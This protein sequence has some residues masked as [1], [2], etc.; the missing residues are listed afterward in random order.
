MQKLTDK[1]KE[2]TT[3]YKRLQRKI[4]ALKGNIMALKDMSKAKR[5]SDDIEK[6]LGNRMKPLSVDIGKATIEIKEERGRLERLYKTY[7]VGICSIV[8]V[9]IIWETF[10]VCKSRSL[11]RKSLQHGLRTGIWRALMQIRGMDSKMPWRGRRNINYN[12]LYIFTF[13]IYDE[14]ESRETKTPHAKKCERRTS[15]DYYFPL[16][17]LLYLGVSPLWFCM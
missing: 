10:L 13:Y 8:V 9:M 5:E 1:G 12:S 7:Y 17:F 14:S 3:D 6:T 16:S 11:M 15:L 2:E 4:I